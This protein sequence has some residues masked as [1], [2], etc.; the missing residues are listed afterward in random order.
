MMSTKLDDLDPR[1][2]PLAYALIAKCVEAHIEVL[3]VCTGRTQ[4]EQD[5]AFAT[6]HSKVR[7]SKHQDGLAIDLCIWD[8]W[9]QHG[10]SKL[11]W[12]TSNP[13]WLKMGQIGE[14][15]GLRWGGRFEPL[16]SH[17]IGWDAGHFE[18]INPGQGA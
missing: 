7:H 11:D 3:I 13:A 8:Q 15:L 2:R 9:A 5:Q 14:S 16:D 4:A 6:G 17:G 1:F 18:M 12:N 10:P